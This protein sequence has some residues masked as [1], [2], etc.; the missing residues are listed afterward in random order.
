[1]TQERTSTVFYRRS[2]LPPIN[3][4]QESV[5]A[6]DPIAE[7]NPHLIP[8]K[9]RETIPHG[10]NSG[11]SLEHL[12]PWHEQMEHELIIKA[13][14]REAC[15]QHVLVLENYKKKGF[16]ALWASLH[17]WLPLPRFLCCESRDTPPKEVAKG[18]EQFSK[19]L[20]CSVSFFTAQ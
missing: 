14:W 12:W 13:T 7:Q 3:E 8:S 2:C 16:H 4:V 17:L 9:A 10:S 11:C 15:K 19:F 1:M 20:H 6:T 5:W 18:C